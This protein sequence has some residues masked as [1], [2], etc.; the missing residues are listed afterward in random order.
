MIFPIR[1]HSYLECDWNMAIVNQKKW[2]ELP[3]EWF[4]EFESARAKP[5]PF[6][7]IEVDKELV[8]KWTEYLDERYAKKCP[9][10][11]RPFRVGCTEGTPSSSKTQSNI[12]WALGRPSD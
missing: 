1:G 6:H 10:K 11:S 2:I 9:F 3:K 12:P 8:R 7:I 5:F 4:E